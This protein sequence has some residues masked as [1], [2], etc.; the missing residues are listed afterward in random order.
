MTEETKRTGRKNTKIGIVV[1][2][3]MDKS[4]M[5]AVDRLVRHGL[6]AK[7]LRRT[8][9]FMAHDEKNQC[10]V[11]DKVQIEECRPLSRR[12]CWMVLKVLAKSA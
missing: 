7:T 6:Y 2:N 9:K 11:G 1:G 8:S 12:K 5:V 10:N 4:V 3:S